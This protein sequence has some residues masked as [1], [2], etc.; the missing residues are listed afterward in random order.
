M[1]CLHAQPR[2]PAM[3]DDRR[4]LPSARARCRL[5][6]LEALSGRLVDLDV[7]HVVKHHT[8]NTAPSDPSERT[9]PALIIGDE[10]ARV[11]VLYWDGEPFFTVWDAYTRYP[12][13]EAG[14]D[15]LA[16]VLAGQWHDQSSAHARLPH[17]R[18]A[19]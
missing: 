6:L 7:P 1:V 5:A 19:R 14:V 15:R 16:V 3:V 10:W 11:R 4:D 12:T 18:S 9:I 8:E 17:V 13:D 2:P